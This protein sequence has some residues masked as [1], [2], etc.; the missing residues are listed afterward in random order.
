MS[1]GIWLD[2]RGVADPAQLPHW[3]SVAQRPGGAELTVGKGAGVR[4]S[5]AP[6]VCPD[7]G[8]GRH[9]GASAS[10]VSCGQD[11]RTTVAEGF[12]QE[13]QRALGVDRWL[14]NAW[15]VARWGRMGPP[16][17]WLV[18]AAV[19]VPDFLTYAR[20]LSTGQAGQ[21]AGLPGSLLAVAQAGL[22]AAPAVMAHPLKAV[23]KDFWVVAE[24]L[25]RYDLALLPGWHR[26]PVLLHAQV[27]DMAFTLDREGFLRRALRL[28]ATRN[29]DVGAQRRGGAEFADASGQTPGPGRDAG[30]ARGAGP[31]ATPF[32]ESGRKTGIHTQQLPTALSCLARWRCCP[33]ILAALW[34][35]GDQAGWLAWE[36]ARETGIPGPMELIGEAT[37]H[38]LDLAAALGRGEH[39]DGGPQPGSWLL[40]PSA[41][42]AQ[43]PEGAEFADAA[44]QN[45]SPCFDPGSAK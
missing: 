23:R 37:C 40:S 34:L 14:L 2:G 28:L 22:S 1:A 31:G 7:Q 12:P 30:N 16:D 32:G 17:D 19:T 29:R 44:G 41:C 21:L 43:R 45:P 27:A 9:G 8:N 10:V 26:G 20:L 25:L 39:S 42:V 11:A 3:E 35:P 15:Q 6:V 18:H 38:P 4:G 24:V 36:S 13:A 5:E 33:D